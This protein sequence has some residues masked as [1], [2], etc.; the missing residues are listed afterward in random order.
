ML[1]KDFAD[2]ITSIRN[3]D[4]RHK[5]DSALAE[6]IDTMCDPS[7]ESTGDTDGPIDYCQLWGKRLLFCDSQGFVSI[8]KYPT[9]TDARRVFDT[10][11]LAYWTWSEDEDSEQDLDDVLAF[12]EYVV[13]C[14][15]ESLEPHSF[16]MWNV[17][18]RPAG[19]LG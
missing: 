11:E 19:P 3:D 12:A 15:T 14:A 2:Q 16:H 6:Y 9:E 18:N 8:D 7:D 1:C 4:T 13:A 10:I 5:Y 17:H